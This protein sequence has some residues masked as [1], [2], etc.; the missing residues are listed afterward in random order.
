MLALYFFLATLVS[1]VAAQS[2]AETSCNPLKT[3]CPPDPALSTE[4]TFWF[5]ETLDDTLWNMTSGSLDYTSEGAQFTLNEEGDS[6]L[7]MSN[8]YIFFGVMEV[9]AKMATGN[10]IISG[11]ILESDDLDEID[12]E[13][14][15]SNTTGVQSDFFGKGNTTTWNRGAKHNAANANLDFHNYTT[16]WDQEKLQ[17]WV[18]GDM[19]RQVNYSERLTVYGQNYPQTP[20]RVKASLWPSGVEGES[21]GTI[22]WGGGMVDWSQAP[23]TMTIQRIRVEDF[24]S[25]KE[26]QYDGTSGSFHSINVIGG[27]STAEDRIA[28]PPES[29]SEKWDDLPEGAHIGVYCGAAAAGALV[30]VAVGLYC[31]KQRRRGRLEHALDDARYNTERNEMETYQNDW[32]Q[33]EWSSTSIRHNGYQAM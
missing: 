14:V 33:T 19:V 21:P 9:H 6:L 27:N 22:K 5:N 4:H 26:Y 12:W 30:V 24:S 7:L 29:L 25:G 15:G 11:V 16:Y 28:H 32:K 18:D 17:W 3:T 2:N 20:C 10:G 13:W 8:F 23:F 1:Y 31:L